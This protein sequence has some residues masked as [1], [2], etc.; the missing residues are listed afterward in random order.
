MEPETETAYIKS[1]IPVAVLNVSWETVSRLWKGAHTSESRNFA[2]DEC[3]GCESE[4][5]KAE[6]DFKR[7]CEDFTSLYDRRSPVGKDEAPKALPSQ[8]SPVLRR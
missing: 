6:E 2:S 5:L 7:R 1:G 3:A 4:H 8:V